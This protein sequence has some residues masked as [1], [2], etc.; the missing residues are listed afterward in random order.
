MSVAQMGGFACIHMTPD[1]LRYHEYV[2]PL[3]LLTNLRCIRLHMCARLCVCSGE[4]TFGVNRALEC[5]SS[6]VEMLTHSVL[7][8]ILE[9][10]VAGFRTPG[11]SMDQF[12]FKALGVRAQKRTKSSWDVRFSFG[13]EHSRKMDS[14]GQVW[15]QQSL[16]AQQTKPM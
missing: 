2:V 12:K 8:E 10:P 1:T 13:G 6:T 15:P 11:H 4:T 16:P 7:T 9:H 5:H 3:K 14:D